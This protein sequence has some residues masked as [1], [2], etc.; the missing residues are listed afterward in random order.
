MVLGLLSG[1]NKVEPRP[2]L[3]PSGGLILIS[4][5]AFLWFL[6]ESDP[7]PPPL[8]LPRPG[9]CHSPTYFPVN[10]RNWPSLLGQDSWIWSKFFLFT[11]NALSP[12]IKIE[13]LIYCPYN[14]SIEVSSR[15]NFEN[16]NLKIEILIYCPYNF[17]IEVS[18]R[19][20]LLKNQLLG[21]SSLIMTSILMTTL[22]SKELRRRNFML[23]TWPRRLLDFILWPKR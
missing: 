14:F 15:E 18:S 12:N 17:S 10:M 19:E 23:I 2:N 3:S 22:F 21:P 4:R 8:G 16:E 20:N 1:S 13:I 5:Q 6:Y 9:A 7:P 11:F